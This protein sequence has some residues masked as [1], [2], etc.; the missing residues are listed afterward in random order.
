M[1]RNSIL[2]FFFLILSQFYG[3]VFSQQPT[4]KEEWIKKLKKIEQSREDLANKIWRLEELLSSYQGSAK[5][6]DGICAKIIHRLG[7]YYS[8]TGDFENGIAFTKQAV[9]LNRNPAIRHRDETFLANSYFNLGAF[10]G[11]LHFTQEF[12]LYMD[13]C[14]SIAK[15]YP[16]KGYIG[17]N[18]FERKAAYYFQIGDNYTSIEMADQGLIFSESQPV[19]KYVALVYLQ[20]AQSLLALG[21]IEEAIIA[22]DK[23]FEILPQVVYTED[24][25]ALAYSVYALS[26]KEQGDVEN[27]ISF[28]EQAIEI[29]LRNRDYAN[30]IKNLS[31]I[32][33]LYDEEKADSKKALECYFKGL[34]IIKKINDPVLLAT[35]NNNIGTLFLSNKKFTDALHYFQKGLTEFTLGFKNNEWKSNPSLEQVKTTNNNLILFSLLS[36]KGETLL[37]RYRMEADSSYLPFALNCFKLTD[38]SVDLMRWNQNNEQTKYFWREKTKS[39]YE[40]AIETCFQLQDVDNALY[41]FEK[42]RAAM[43]NDKLR[44]LGSKQFLSIE[45]QGLERELRVRSVSLQQK[46]E[47][48]DP[49]DPAYQDLLSSRYQIMESYDKF[50]KSLESKYPSYYRYKYDTGFLSLADLRSKVLQK[51]QTFISYF[52]GKNHLYA[53]TIDAKSASLK[54]INKDQYEQN[55]TELA[56]LSS[57]K[58]RLNQKYSRYRELAHDLYV[59]IFQPLMVKTKRVV[60]SPDD[61]FIPFE[62]LLKDRDHSNSFLLQDHAFSYTYSAGFLNSKQEKIPAQSALLAMAPVNYQAHLQQASLRGADISLNTIQNNFS[63]S[64]YYVQEQATKNEFLKNLPKYSI[65]HLYSHAKADVEGTEPSI[66]FYDSALMVSD[67]QLL[68]NLPTKLIVLSACNTGVGKNLKGEGVFSL[69]R[70]FAA[71]GIPSSITSLW[72]IDNHSTYQISEMFYK[73]LV[74][75]LP[76]DVAL[77]EAKLEF[78]R[79]QDRSYD[80]PYYW[81]GSILL[82]NS[83]GFLPETDHSIL[84]FPNLAGVFLIVLFLISTLVYHKKYRRNNFTS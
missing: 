69:A 43:L 78:L 67:L 82:G 31:N 63:S 56:L 80:L 16:E 37:D 68:G 83:D 33:I 60:I 29:H 23:A 75:G 39:M 61:H 9:S 4:N 12:S 3:S 77:Q 57:E 48:T 47:Q 8:K 79:V 73:F 38:K 28:Y 51:D 15:K 17:T 70:G 81:A 49:L 62:L 42:S 7:D 11:D 76:L 21:V 24:D 74:Q 66:Y 27:A 71:A 46:L 25:A 2:F 6:L 58:A 50:I 40:N 20:K 18:A 72:K 26:L 32:G 36:N 84:R 22:I 5:Y 13:S 65:V 34:E 14:I 53:L 30:A 10:Y 19:N 1:R 45:D 59:Q 35:V 64:Q 54:K 55:A 44:E 52:N 41:F